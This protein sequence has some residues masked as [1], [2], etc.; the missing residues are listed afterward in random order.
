MLEDEN[1]VQL[2]L[3][4]C[5]IY[6]YL[7]TY[8][9]LLTDTFLFGSMFVLNVNFDKF[10]IKPILFNGSSLVTIT[11]IMEYYKAAL[12]CLFVFL[13]DVSLVLSQDYSNI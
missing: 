1:K 5:Y 11:T 3:L 4:L 7:Q 10:M 2:F 8:L 9:K 13:N 12:L 6:V